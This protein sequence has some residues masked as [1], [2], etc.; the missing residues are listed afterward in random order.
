MKA[1][2]ALVGTVGFAG[3]MIDGIIFA[4]RAHHYQDLNQPMPNGKS[5]FMT[6]RDGYSIASVFI[7]MSVLWLVMAFKYW[8]SVISDRSS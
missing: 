8:R 5:G 4:L 3:F 6:F 7:L 1:L 2:K